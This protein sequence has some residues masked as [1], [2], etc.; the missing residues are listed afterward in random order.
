MLKTGTQGGKEGLKGAQKVNR[1]PLV[2][3]KTESEQK[4]GRGRRHKKGWWRTGE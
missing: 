3:A 4:A 2:E 1:G